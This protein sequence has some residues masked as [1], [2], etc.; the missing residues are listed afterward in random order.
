MTTGSSNNWLVGEVSGRFQPFAY[1]FNWRALT[2]PL[3]DGNGSYGS[4]QDS[5]QFCLADGSVRTLSE[6]TEVSVIQQLAKAPP[7]ATPQQTKCPDRVFE[8]CNT[9]LWTSSFLLAQDEDWR[10]SHKGEFGTKLCFDPK[11]KLDT[12]SVYTRS[13]GQPAFASDGHT[14]IDLQGIIEQYP[15][16]R[17]IIV[18]TLT[19]EV[20]ECIAKCPAVETIVVVSIQVTAS[21]RHALQG[22]KTL[23]RICLKSGVEYTPANVPSTAGIFP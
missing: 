18:D 9:K 12:A 11:G 2:L 15:E 16:V 1:P 5:G 19:D 8:Y 3:N 10:H 21:G 20:A 6:K 7:V 23:K 22:T 14:R 4:F 17:V 13:D